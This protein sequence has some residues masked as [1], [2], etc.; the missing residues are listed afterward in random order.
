[1]GA[2]GIQPWEDDQAADW[3]HRFF[4]GVNANARIR[5]AFRDRNNLPL[6]RAACF[7]LGTLGR[8]YVW[9]GDRKELRQLLEQGEALLTRMARPSAEDRQDNDFLE[10]WDDDPDFL[11][12]VRAQAA[13]LRKRRAELQG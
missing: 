5:S 6:I 10:Y 1:M 11:K 4:K 2:W 13:E 12:A 7:L 3:F 9:P 8:P